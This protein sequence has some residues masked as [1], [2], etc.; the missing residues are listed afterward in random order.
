MPH[1]RRL[2]LAPLRLRRAARAGAR[3]DRG[4]GARRA[5]VHGAGGSRNRPP[6]Q[7]T[8]LRAPGA[9][10]GHGRGQPRAGL[11]GRLARVRDRLSD[12][13]RPRPLDRPAAHEQ[14]SEDGE[15]DRL[16][17]QG[18]RAGGDRGAAQHRECALPAGKAREA[19][20]PPPSPGPEVRAGRR[21]N[22]HTDEPRD[23]PLRD[24]STRLRPP[25]RIGPIE[26]QAGEAEI[27]Y[28]DEPDEEG[29]VQPLGEPAEAE[30]AVE[31]PEAAVAEP[32]E[33][34]PEEQA[35]APA[36]EH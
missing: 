32:A 17:P 23:W 11:P 30:S 31:P 36:E 4:R 16:R 24:W 9:G 15:R 14:S 21:M 26:A 7:A 1:G 8:R 20:S 19:R 2:P 12:P 29:P 3:P 27:L 6:E 25:R 28:E 5:A 22:E 34:P 13:G 35:E 18:R 10:A 33:A